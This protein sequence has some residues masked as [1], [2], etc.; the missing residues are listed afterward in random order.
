MGS[1][2]SVSPDALEAFLCGSI[3]DKIYF[4]LGGNQVIL[5]NDVCSSW[6]NRVGDFLISVLDRI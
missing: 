5:V 6:C 4:W 2:N 3:F 1:W